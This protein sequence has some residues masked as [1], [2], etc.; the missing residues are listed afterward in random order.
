VLVKGRLKEFK[1]AYNQYVNN[2]EDD[3]AARIGVFTFR[4]FLNLGMLLTESE[5]V[6]QLMY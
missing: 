5:R 3:K 4:A 2:L 1:D 6:K